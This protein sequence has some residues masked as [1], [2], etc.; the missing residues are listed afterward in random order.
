MF[1]LLGYTFTED[2]EGEQ[3]T[4]HGGQPKFGRKT[5]PEVVKHG[6]GQAAI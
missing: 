5:L 1:S 6:K 3:A 2:R 4:R